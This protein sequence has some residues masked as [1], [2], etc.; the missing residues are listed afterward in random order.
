MF[1]SAMQAVKPGRTVALGVN[2]Y[3]KRYAV[4]ELKRYKRDGIPAGWKRCGFTFDE[5]TLRI[6]KQT[7]ELTGADMW[8]VCVTTA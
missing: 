5:S 1:L 2:H 6:E 8:T 3:R 7:G 4:E